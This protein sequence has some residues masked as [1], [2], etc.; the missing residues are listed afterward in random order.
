AAR[1]EAAA[2]VD[3][4]LPVEAT[5]G[6][7]LTG[8]R[9]VGGAQLLGEEGCRGGVGR[10]EPGP[11]ADLRTVRGAGGAAAVV[12]VVQL[13]VGSAGQQFHRLREGEVVDLLDEGDD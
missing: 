4:D 13:D 11:L 2:E 1:R 6:E 10:D 3:R 7:E 8:G 5:L 9:R 12:L